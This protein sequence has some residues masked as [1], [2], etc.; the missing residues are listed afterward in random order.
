M[1][2]FESNVTR[3]SNNRVQSIRD[4]YVQEENNGEKLSDYML[5]AHTICKKDRKMREKKCSKTMGNCINQW[6]CWSSKSKTIGE[7]KLL[8]LLILTM[9]QKILGSMQHATV[10]LIHIKA[11][12]SVEKRKRDQS[13][14]TETQGGEAVLSDD[15]R[16][17]RTS[18][19]GE[20]PRKKLYH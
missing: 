17:L 9:F 16:R 5:C 11:L 18:G 3:W 4:G 20:T 7:L 1:L 15:A 2:W 13:N 14:I 19:T 12:D 6:L 10:S 8:S